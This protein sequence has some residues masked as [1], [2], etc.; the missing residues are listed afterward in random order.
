MQQFISHGDFSF[1]FD[2]ALYLL[3][4]FFIWSFQSGAPN[5]DGIIRLP[6]RILN[7]IVFAISGNIGVSYFY[8]FSSLLIAFVA[9]FYFTKHFLGVKSRS[10]QFICALF[11][12]VN[13]IFLGNLAKIGLVLAACMLPLCLLAIKAAFEQRRL[14]YLLLYVACLNIALIHPYT[15]AVN[16]GISG[17]YL[18][19][20]I[21]MYPGFFT[22]HL[23][24]FLGIGILALLLH[25]YFILPIAALGTI[26]KDVLSD[27][28]DATP[29]DYTALVDL[30]TSDALTGLSMSKDIFLDF[31]FY[32]N[33]YESFYFLGAFGFYIILLGAYLYIEKR[34]TFN[35]KQHI[36]LFFSAFLLLIALTTLTI[37]HLNEIIKLLIGLP[38]G[39]AFRSPLKWQLYIPMALFSILA[40]VLYKVSG[41]VIKVIGVGLAASFILMNGYL[42]ADIFQ[43]ILTPRSVETFAAL[44]EK[45]DLDNKTLLFVSSN[46]CLD[47]LRDNPKIKTEMN[48]VFLSKNV[49]VKRVSAD[50]VTGVNFGSYDYVMGCVSQEALGKT[51]AE[52]YKIKLAH[53]FAN[54]NFKLY[55]NNFKPGPAYALDTIFSHSTSEPIDNKYSF[56][57]DILEKPFSYATEQPGKKSVPTT[58]LS[59]I[60]ETLKAD[61]L[62]NGQIIVKTQPTSTDAHSLYV[63][64]SDQPLFYTI[65]GSQ[66]NLSPRQITG[67]KPLPTDQSP[68]SLPKAN[69]FTVTYSDNEFKPRNLIQNP[70]LEKG[71]WQKKVS[72]CYAYDNKPAI[73]M[74]L[75]QEQKTNGAKSLQ[76]ESKSHIACTGPSTIPVN[77]KGNYLLSFD[78]QSLRKKYAGYNVTFDDPLGTTI[79]ERLPKAGDA[80]NTFTRQIIAPEGARHLKLM[81][82]AY[83]I[84][85]DD[86]TFNT[87]RYDNF[88]LMSM[89][90]LKDIFYL[91]SHSPQETRQPRSIMTTVADPTKKIVH[92]KGAKKP[93]YLATNETYHNS[94]QLTFDKKSVGD[95]IKLNNSA[96][97]WYVD[98]NTF[99]QNN[100][101]CTK[102]DDGYNFDVVMEFLP[103]RSFYTGAIIS[104]TTLILI[105]LYLVYDHK[106]YLRKT[107]W[108]GFKQR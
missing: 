4:H 108:K 84:N 91:V 7:F 37:F 34:L 79:E 57:S 35:Q 73:A 29:V 51:L 60:F 3:K 88:N 39:W 76:L 13:P 27:T 9:F 28:V 12:A 44:G 100:S 1:P 87:V 104:F 32:D 15:F 24:K 41:R 71:T 69:Q 98:P 53:S 62:Q 77:E 22:K 61:N 75:N 50:D 23:G 17:I 25:A 19:Y 90:T 78:Y 67:S 59:D 11:F 95:H 10:I 31:N 5:P 26:S 66:I 64:P 14:R 40:I 33:N 20:Q 18:L 74:K 21:W 81:L 8:I 55:A 92:V 43:K 99:C 47:Y 65:N 49:Q 107:N 45:V 58:G 70:S 48:Q 93:F 54:D 72:D 2:W 82:Y 85:N 106:R 96:N 56:A 105:I 46:G 80:W 83:P 42:S 103:Q 16:L 52:K 38:G 36:V 30:S 6:G 86:G 68:I 89:P 97:G 101:A 63:K 102:N 94:W